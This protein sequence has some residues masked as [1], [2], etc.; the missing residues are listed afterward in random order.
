V[1]IGVCYD[2]TGF[3]EGGWGIMERNVAGLIEEARRLPVS[4]QLNLIEQLARSVQSELEA[5]ATLRGELAAWDMLSDEAL[6][7]FEATL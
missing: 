6:E 2:S 3:I 7:R 1:L 4:Q 5:T